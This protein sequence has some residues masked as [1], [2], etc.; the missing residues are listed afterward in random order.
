M[1]E[2]TIKHEIFKYLSDA[3]RETERCNFYHVNDTSED[4]QWSYQ[5]CW[6]LSQIFNDLHDRIRASALLLGDDSIPSD[7]KIKQVKEILEKNVLKDKK[8]IQGVFYDFSYLENSERFI[9]ED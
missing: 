3:I 7:K 9:K 4:H 2:V 1:Q 5:A 6:E 8:D